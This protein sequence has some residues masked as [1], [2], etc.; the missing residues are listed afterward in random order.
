[1]RKARHQS[2]ASGP[3]LPKC[4]RY[5]LGNGRSAATKEANQEQHDCDR[6]EHPEEDD[7][8]A[9][10]RTCDSAKTEERRY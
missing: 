10:S 3:T 9:R 5:G 2:L 6:K 4:C 7:R 8:E 1:M